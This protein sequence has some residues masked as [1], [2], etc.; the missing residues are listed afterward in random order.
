MDQ[1][2]ANLSSLRGQ[3]IAEAPQKSI[4]SFK[5]RVEMDQLD[6]LQEPLDAKHLLLRGTLLKNTSWILGLVVYTG[7]ETRMVM[8]SRAA[9]A[10]YP[11]IEKVINRSMLVVVG[12]QCI[13]ALISDILYLV[14]KE[15]FLSLWYLFPAGQFQSILLPEFIGYWLTFFVP[16][17]YQRKNKFDFRTCRIFLLWFPKFW[18][19]IRKH[20]IFTR[21]WP[22]F[23]QNLHQNY[24]FQNFRIFSWRF[25]FLWN[26]SLEVLRSDFLRNKS[27]RLYS[28]LMPISL[29]FTMEVCNAAQARA[30]CRWKHDLNWVFNQLGRLIS[31]RMTWRCM[32]RPWFN[33]IL[34][35]FFMFCRWCWTFQGTRHSS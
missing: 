10:K 3:V 30:V 32:T 33:Y 22:G 6:H 17:D 24:G 8:N 34:Y 23:Q 15:R 29:Y 13:M 26:I 1:A 11:N 5:G 31:L 25:L 35:S 7:A 4:H 27:S 9:K 19:M 21:F 20:D 16:L 14:T 18:W 12:A 28:N 2:V